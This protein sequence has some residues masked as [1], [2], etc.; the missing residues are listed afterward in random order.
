MVQPSWQLCISLSLK[1][2][3]AASPYRKP[4]EANVPRPALRADV[5]RTGAHPPKLNDCGKLQ[6]FILSGKKL[7]ISSR[8]DFAHHISA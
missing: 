1:A 6:I 3:N 5:P 7:E 2:T 8:H 4:E